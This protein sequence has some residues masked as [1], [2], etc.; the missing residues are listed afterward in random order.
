MNPFAV[1]GDLAFVGELGLSGELRA[2]AQLPARLHEAA[3]LGFKRVV[4]PRSV[5]R[6]GDVPSAL[7]IHETRTLREALHLVLDEKS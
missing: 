3:K 2:V 5:R 1:E 7:Q 4:I 6:T